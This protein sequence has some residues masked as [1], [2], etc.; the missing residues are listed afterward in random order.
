MI[1]TRV[2]RRTMRHGHRKDRSSTSASFA[3]ISTETVCHSHGHVTSNASHLYCQER[4][5][6]ESPGFLKTN[7]QTIKK[8][9]TN[10]KYVQ[11][12]EEKENRDD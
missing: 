12:K 8:Q 1:A 3:T 9:T 5:V 10:N 4:I 7:K 2:S 6:M 11:K